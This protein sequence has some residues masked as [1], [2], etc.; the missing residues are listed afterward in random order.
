MI[1]TK[2][3][4]KKNKK[5]MEPPLQTT[6]PK[7]NPSIEWMIFPI[8]ENWKNTVAFFLITFGL[9]AI[10]QISF[11]ERWLTLLSAIFL[12]GSLRMFWTPTF[13]KVDDKGVEVKTP[14]YKLVHPWSRFRALKD[15]PRGLIL[16]PFKSESRLEAY[17]ALFLRLPPNSKELKQKITD[18]VLNYLPTDR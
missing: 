7:Q 15:D 16:S 6:E 10:I 11:Q 3:T 4:M 12:F 17:R 5:I 1:F 8:T 14:F 2:I 18:V 9:I 13:Y